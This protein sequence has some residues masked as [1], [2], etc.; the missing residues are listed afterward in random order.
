MCPETDQT[1]WV[2]VSVCVSV[3][4]FSSEWT[5]SDSL[6]DHR[7]RLQR[8]QSLTRWLLHI[9]HS[10][11]GFKIMVYTRHQS[12]EVRIRRQQ[13]HLT[14]HKTYVFHVS[15]SFFIIVVWITALNDCSGGKCSRTPRFFFPKHKTPHHHHFKKCSSESGLH[16]FFK[17]TKVH[18]HS[19]GIDC[20]CGAISCGGAW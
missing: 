18:T 16:R 8:L 5:N 7:H 14:L 17:K 19:R 11:Q 10:R 2:C 4:C 12:Y 3:S 13:V 15:R 6:I 1:G 9:R 20:S